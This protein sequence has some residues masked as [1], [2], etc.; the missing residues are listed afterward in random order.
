MP[1]WYQHVVS[2]VQF[3]YQHYKTSRSIFVRACCFCTSRD[4]SASR[5]IR[6]C[7]LGP[8]NTE[9]RCEQWKVSLESNDECMF[10]LLYA[11]LVLRLGKINRSDLIQVAQILVTG[12]IWN[13]HS[14]TET[15]PVY[16]I[17]FNRHHGSF[18]LLYQEINYDQKISERE[19][20]WPSDH[21]S[22]Q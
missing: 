3:R 9:R 2:S 10:N 13:Q 1:F 6:M 7:H 22:K 4:S 17:M 5:R 21:R 12:V 16:Y 15:K 18:S 8:R 20:C 19:K 11:I 14:S